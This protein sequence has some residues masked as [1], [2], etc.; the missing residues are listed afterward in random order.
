MTAIVDRDSPENQAIAERLQ[1]AETESLGDDVLLPAFVALNGQ[2]VEGMLP[3]FSAP[4]L[5]IAEA[6]LDRAEKNGLAAAQADGSYVLLDMVERQ[7]I[8][9]FMKLGE[10]MQRTADRLT[11]R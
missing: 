10:D 9:R 3:L 1:A 4:T 11:L 5:E 6:T 2:S 8:R 7:E